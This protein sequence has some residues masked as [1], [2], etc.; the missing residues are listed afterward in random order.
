MAATHPEATPQNPSHPASLWQHK[1]IS[2]LSFKHKYHKRLHNSRTTF[3]SL[4]H[5]AK[6]NIIVQ[7][8]FRWENIGWQKR[9]FCKS[10]G[11]L[12]FKCSSNGDTIVV[13]CNKETFCTNQVLKSYRLG[14]IKSLPFL[15]PNDPI[16]SVQRS[17]GSDTKIS[18]WYS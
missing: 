16:L 17:T 12:S 5:N 7:W 9:I 3:Q 10:F 11:H 8:S 14:Q 15:F 13:S 4:I 6:F 18:L 1:T 2:W